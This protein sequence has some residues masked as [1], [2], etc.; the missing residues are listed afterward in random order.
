MFKALWRFI[1]ECLEAL[2]DDENDETLSGRPRT[3]NYRWHQG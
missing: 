1:T 3:E 2:R